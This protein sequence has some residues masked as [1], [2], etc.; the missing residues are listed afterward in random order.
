MA[1]GID[2][3]GVGATLRTYAFDV[4][5]LNL[6][7]RFEHEPSCLGDN[8]SVL[9]YDGIASIYNILGALAESA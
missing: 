9:G 3:G 6:H 8:L 4:N 5:L 7:L 1:L 2:E